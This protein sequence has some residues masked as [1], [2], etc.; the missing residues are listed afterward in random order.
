MNVPYAG[1]DKTSGFIV[2]TLLIVVG[3]VRLFVLFRREK[4]L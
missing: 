4:W 3:A 2:S 1:Y